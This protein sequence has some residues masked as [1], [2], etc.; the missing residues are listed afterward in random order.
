MTNLQAIGARVRELR[1]AEGIGQQELAVIIG[2][3][4]STLA[5]IE[6]GKDRGG[7]ETMIA[8]ADHYKVPMDWLLGRQLEKPCALCMHASYIPII[9]IIY[10]YRKTSIE[11][12]AMIKAT[13]TQPDGRKVLVLGL[14]F[15]NLDRFRAEP[16]NTYINIDGNELGLP[17]DVMI[18]SG[19][20]QQ[21][22]AKLI[23]GAIGPATRVHVVLPRPKS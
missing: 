22:L 20:T 16:G 9:D 18:F 7:I 3:S 2:I 4:R 1:I 13:A 15:A 6:T 10:A 12:R 14:S 5:G 11:E 8:I 21:H 23:E 17:I 19:E